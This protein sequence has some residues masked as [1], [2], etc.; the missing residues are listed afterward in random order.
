MTKK[1]HQFY[2]IIM[3]LPEFDLLNQKCWPTLFIYFSSQFFDKQ[4][5]DNAKQTWYLWLDWG[6]SMIHCSSKTFILV[7]M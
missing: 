4:L 3:K 6:A 2:Q 5:P 7:C 1:I